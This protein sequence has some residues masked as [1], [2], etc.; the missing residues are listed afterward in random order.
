MKFSIIIPVYNVE[1]YLE[2]CLLSVLQQEYDDYEIIIV[3][4]GS[5]DKSGLICDEYAEKNER[6]SVMHIPNGGVSN[7]RNVGLKEAKGEFVWFIDSDDYIVPGALQVLD[8]YLERYKNPDMLLFNAHVVNE[9]GEIKGN[10]CCNLKNEKLLTFEKNRDIVFTN[11]SLWNRIYKL[12]VIKRAN[13]AFKPRI[14]IGEDLLFNYAYFLE[15]REIYCEKDMLYCY[16]QRHNS[17]MSGAGKDKHVQEVFE[18][19]IEYYKTKDKYED[20]KDEIEYLAIYH[21]F[22]VTSVRLA[23]MCADKEECLKIAKWFKENNIK[24]SLHNPYVRKMQKKHILVFVL[25]KLRC[26][27]IIAMLLGKL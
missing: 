16:V 15:A 10:V 17:A 24:V 11:T 27:R 3:D 2:R 8:S 19:L 4:D 7:A 13:L 1:K 18:T 12:E 6:I 14:T 20:Y 22:I 23:R 9:E 25:L 5:K 26:Y 21:Y